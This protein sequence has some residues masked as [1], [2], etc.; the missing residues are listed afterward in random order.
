[1]KYLNEDISDRAERDL[2]SLIKI[3]DASDLL[4][5]CEH[6]L[7]LKHP[8]TRAMRHEV[9]RLNGEHEQPK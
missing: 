4:D 5:A 2:I 7:G 3:L 1:M 8:S 9:E 6:V